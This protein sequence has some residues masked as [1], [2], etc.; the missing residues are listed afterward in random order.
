LHS[1]CYNIYNWLPDFYEMHC[2]I[3]LYKLTCG[4]PCPQCQVII[5]HTGG[6]KYMKCEKCKY[7]FCWWCLDEFYTEYHFHY[8]TCP[9]RHRLLH[10]IE[11]L[12]IFLIIVKIISVSIFLQTILWAIKTATGNL[13]LG[14]ILAFMFHHFT[15][16]YQKKLSLQKRLISR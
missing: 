7:E 2:F 10:S 3:S 15:W 11:I 5:V 9:F 12:L 16:N 6:C 13:I 8:T 1:D 4:E 14:F